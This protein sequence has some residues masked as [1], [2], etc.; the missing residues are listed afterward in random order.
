MAEQN[1]NPM[2]NIS[3]YSQDL[4]IK[5]NEAKDLFNVITLQYH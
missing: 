1:A 2:N 3:V 5:G 4:Q